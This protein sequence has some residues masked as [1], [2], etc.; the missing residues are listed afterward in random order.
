MVLKRY[1]LVRGEHT[2]ERHCLDWMRALS[3]LGL[4]GYRP[5]DR[6]TNKWSRGQR[7]KLF[8]QVKPKVGPKSQT[9]SNSPHYTSCLPQGCKTVCRLRSAA[10]EL[11]NTHWFVCWKLVDD[12]IICLILIVCSRSSLE[13]GLVAGCPKTYDVWTKTD[14]I[15]FKSVVKSAHN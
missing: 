12:I 1:S 10:C 14:Y 8:Q 11:R 6:S 5:G 15:N 4:L 13:Q 3:K 9:F 2:N 7:V